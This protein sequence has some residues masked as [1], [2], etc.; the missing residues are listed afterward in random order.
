MVKQKRAPVAAL[1]ADRCVLAIRAKGKVSSA[2]V[3]QQQM[4]S[5]G[6]SLSMNK[7]CNF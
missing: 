1:R 3:S 5:V 7:H 4:Y 2:V 6:C